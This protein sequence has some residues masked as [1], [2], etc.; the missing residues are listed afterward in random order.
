MNP[1]SFQTFSTTLI[2]KQPHCTPETPCQEHHFPGKMRS[3]RS[4]G[5][6]VGLICATFPPI[7]F[8]FFHYTN[9]AV[10]HISRPDRS[11]TVTL[12]AH[13]ALLEGRWEIHRTL[14]RPSDHKGTP[15]LVWESKSPVRDDNLED[16][17]GSGSKRGCV[18]LFPNSVHLHGASITFVLKP[19]APLR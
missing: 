9:V 10:L 8:V 15:S 12:T 14:S 17:D 5:R 11:L 1:F 16:D 13:T 4:V 18:T 2:F 6:L 7:R 19:T 3:R